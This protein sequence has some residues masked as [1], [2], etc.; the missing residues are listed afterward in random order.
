VGQQVRSYISTGFDT[1]GTAG[2]NRTLRVGECHLYKQNFSWVMSFELVTIA[3][4][5]T[6]INQC[7]CQNGLVNRDYDIVA[8]DDFKIEGP[9]NLRCV[10]RRS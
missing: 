5:S 1:S 8:A 7:V 3:Y 10:I 2:T 6:I 4:V 9:N